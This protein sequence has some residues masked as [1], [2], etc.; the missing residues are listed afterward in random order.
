MI[1]RILRDFD[2]TKVH[3]VMENLEWTYR[4]NEYSPTIGELYQTAEYVLREACIKK[5]T[6]STGGFRASY[7]GSHFE[8]MFIVEYKDANR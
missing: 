6:I 3:K 5:A 4:G 8:L 1:E 2:F 7:D